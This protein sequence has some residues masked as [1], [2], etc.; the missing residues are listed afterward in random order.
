MENK[1]CEWCQQEITVKPV[2]HDSDL[3]IYLHFDC[4]LKD[5]EIDNLIQGLTD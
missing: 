1:I 4:S 3:D 5:L 2:I